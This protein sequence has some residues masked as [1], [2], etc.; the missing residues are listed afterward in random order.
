MQT[1]IA[2]TPGRL[3]VSYSYVALMPRDVQSGSAY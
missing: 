3:I 1:E 2:D